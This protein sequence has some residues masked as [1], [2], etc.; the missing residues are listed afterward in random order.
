MH[1]E[2]VEAA[3]RE[4]HRILSDNGATLAKT[5]VARL[6]R[7]FVRAK[8]PCS[9]A[10]YIIRNAAQDLGSASPHKGARTATQ[11]QDPTGEQAVALVMKSNKRQENAA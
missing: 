8:P 7:D 2:T 9:F 4:A 6:A 10:S 1:P 11:W 5:K 3:I